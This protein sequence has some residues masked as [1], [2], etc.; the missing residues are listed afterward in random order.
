[1]IRNGI[2]D[3]VFANETEAAAFGAG[4]IDHGINRVAERVSQV[5]VT[6]GPHGA[7]GIEHGA[8][9]HVPA[10]HVDRVVDTTGAG[11]MFAAGV[12]AGLAKG[13]P[14]KNSLK[15]GASAAASII[16]HYGA[17]AQDNLSGLVSTHAS[18]PNGLVLQ[19]PSQ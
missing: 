11:D 6:H 12:L 15:V 3:I 1:M 19:D 17:R 9:V 5:I 18:A 10:A 2:P 16:S 4:R 13:L 7:L 8:Q 14:L